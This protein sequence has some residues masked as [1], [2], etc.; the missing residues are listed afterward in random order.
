MPHT[1]RIRKQ[2]I[3]NPAKILRGY[4]QATGITA[5]KEL[6]ETF[7]IP[8][9]T[10]QRLKLEC[11][12]SGAVDA[13]A[14]D[15][16]YGAK[17]DANSAKRAI[18]GVSGDAKR[19]ISGVEPSRAYATKE[20]LR[21]TQS[22]SV[23]QLSYAEPMKLDLKQL[24]EQLFDAA[25]GCLANQAI[26]PGLAMMT[27][28][29]M[30]IESGCDLERDVLPSV[31]MIAAKYPGKRIK[32]WDYFTS[33]IAETKAKRI[34]GLPTVDLNGQSAAQPT[35]HAQVKQMLAEIGVA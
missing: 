1:E 26:A 27:I 25:G 19:A 34:A 12:I 4:M 11:A 16:I 5:A 7:D 28:P 2:D 15:A 35:F 3:S 17:P 23:A 14:D 29:Q 22:I 33:V 30:W 31:R 24:S 6:A 21:D 8:L 32:T 18:N 10:I 13:S 20:S 9:R